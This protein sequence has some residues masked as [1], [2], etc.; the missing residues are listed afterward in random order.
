MSVVASS[1]GARPCLEW[2]AQ[3]GSSP[4]G[5]VRTFGDV[6]HLAALALP[7]TAVL[8]LCW[9][10]ALLLPLLLLL[11]LLLSVAAAAAADSNLGLRVEFHGR[12]SDQGINT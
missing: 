6:N 1:G 4:V 11:L 10:W 5:R 2:Q 12:G 7:S 9:W 3:L 8:R